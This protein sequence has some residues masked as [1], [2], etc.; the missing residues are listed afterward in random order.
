MTR[1]RAPA[2]AAVGDSDR[3]RHP[4]T[5]QSA[6]VRAP[7]GI[8]KNPGR[9]DLGMRATLLFPDREIVETVLRPDHLHR[10]S[11]VLLRAGSR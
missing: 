11:N 2:P 5:T 7:S 1:S 4:M 6:P 3:L 10:L 8:P 9:R